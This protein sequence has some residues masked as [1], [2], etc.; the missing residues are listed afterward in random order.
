MWVV[1][2]CDVVLHFSGRR[3]LDIWLWL[4]WISK[5]FP[6][7]DLWDS[8]LCYF[9]SYFSGS[10]VEEMKFPTR[11]G[12]QISI[13]F[14]NFVFLQSSAI[15]LLSVMNQRELSAHLPYF[16]FKPVE[17]NTLLL[18]LERTKVCLLTQIWHYH[19]LKA[20]VVLTFFFVSNDL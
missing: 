14:S 12:G 5:I 7:E 1:L 10:C 16:F 2:L 18:T 17:S 13:F 20:D 4:F 3:I 11:N 15:S 6:N 19:L 9:W 8:V